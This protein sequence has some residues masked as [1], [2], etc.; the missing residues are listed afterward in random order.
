MEDHIESIIAK[1]SLEINVSMKKASTECEGNTKA[2]VAK[3]RKKI[4]EE[5]EKE[6]EA[7]AVSDNTLF[8]IFYTSLI[9]RQLYISMFIHT[10][11]YEYLEIILGV[12]K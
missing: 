6:K 4:K 10:S 11:S 9:S 5:I 2:S 1:R 7:K 12:A 3:K 8:Y